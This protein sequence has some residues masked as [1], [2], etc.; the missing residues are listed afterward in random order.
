M[1]RVRVECTHPVQIKAG[2]YKAVEN[3]T[4]KITQEYIVVVNSTT[5]MI[6]ECIFKKQVPSSLDMT[7]VVVYHGGFDHNHDGH[8]N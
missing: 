1:Y 8:N 7:S 4:I 2:Q 6:L 5:R 3:S